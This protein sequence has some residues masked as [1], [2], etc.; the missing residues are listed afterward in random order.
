MS[1]I[2][3]FMDRVDK[4]FAELKKT[5]KIKPKKDVDDKNPK[6]LHEQL[7][8]YKSQ[9]KDA[10]DRIGILEEL[11]KPFTGKEKGRS[12]IIDFLIGG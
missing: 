4:E 11:I 12:A 3:D 7:T 8:G 10:N 2:N 6:L 5:V 9:L 1:K